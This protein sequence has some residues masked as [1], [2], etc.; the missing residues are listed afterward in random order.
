MRQLS[1]RGIGK[2]KWKVCSSRPGMRVLENLQTQEML[3]VCLY[4]FPAQL[5]VTT[6][7]SEILLIP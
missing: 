6:P 3:L 2:T 1:D 4:F 7:S 5:G